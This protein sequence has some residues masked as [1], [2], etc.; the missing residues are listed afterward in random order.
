MTALQLVST[1]R[2][3]AADRA[4]RGAATPAQV[5]TALKTHGLD[6]QPIDR[7]RVIETGASWVY[8]L[9]DWVLKQKKPRSGPVLDLRSLSAR[10]RNA[11]HELAVNRRLS[12]R[13]YAGLRVICRRGPSGLTILEPK[14][15]LAA[16]VLLDWFVLMRRL[17]HAQMLDRLM[18]RGQLSPV[19]ID[20]LAQSLVD[21]HTS[22]APATISADAWLARFDRE[23]MR[24]QPIFERHGADLARQ[25]L[26][27]TEA[28]YARLQATLRRRHTL[29]AVLLGHGDL[30]PAHVCLLEQPQLIDALDVS[31]VLRQIDGWEDL[32]LLGLEC[33]MVGASWVSGRLALSYARLAPPHLNAPGS[34]LVAYYCAHH[35]IVRARLAY[36]H[37]DS[38]RPHRRRDWAA[39]GGRYAAQAWAAADE[40]LR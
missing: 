15:L 12:P 13:V 17:P 2:T 36:A 23:Q 34:A 16:D 5:L 4:G 9:R 28:A 38:T 7:I 32:A 8:L 29:G 1:A 10:E 33:A 18:G 6:G 40:A 14:S 20:R 27:R 37:L 11:R 26:V 30:R 21:A 31:A 19:L 22:A 39:L 24:C 35:A 3:G 25:A